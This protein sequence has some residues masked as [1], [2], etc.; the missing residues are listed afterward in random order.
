MLT[1]P[2]DRFLRAVE[3]SNGDAQRARRFFAVMC[4]DQSRQGCFD[5]LLREFAAKGWVREERSRL[6]I[7]PKGSLA[8]G[9]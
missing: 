4:P 7:T 3:H 6:Y 8:L 5:S 1:E 2:E 9:L